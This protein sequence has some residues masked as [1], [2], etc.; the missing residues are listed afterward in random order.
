[1]V[2]GGEGCM[3]EHVQIYTVL[4]DIVEARQNVGQKKE[5]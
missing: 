3:S 4:Y 1:M 5:K 2:K